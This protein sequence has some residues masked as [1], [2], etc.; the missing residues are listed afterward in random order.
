MSHNV[1]AY[2]IGSQPGQTG[3]TRAQREGL[4]NDF[5][6]PSP[7]GLKVHPIGQ[8]VRRV[9]RRAIFLLQVALP[10]NP[11]YD[12]RLCSI[13]SKTYSQAIAAGKESQKSLTISEK[14]V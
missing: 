11:V 12:S 7:H 3:V 8:T 6:Y 1:S 5:A 9:Y 2:A 10:K 13:R 4:A 14:A